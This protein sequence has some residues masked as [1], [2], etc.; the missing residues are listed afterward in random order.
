MVSIETKSFIP[1]QT[2][3]RQIFGVAR[4]IGAQKSINHTIV[5]KRILRQQSFVVH[6]VQTY[7]FCVLFGDGD[8]ESHMECFTEEKT[9]QTK[10]DI[11]YYADIFEKNSH[12]IWFFTSILV[13]LYLLCMYVCAHIKYSIKLKF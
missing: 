7:L 3:I 1:N 5:L 13:I 8:D 2:Q 4:G 10:A 6:M 9:K 11:K 12:R